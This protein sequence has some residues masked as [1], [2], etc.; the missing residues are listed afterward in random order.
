MLIIVRCS[1][2][3]FVLLL[4]CQLANVSAHQPGVGHHG[5]RGMSGR[6]CHGS[7]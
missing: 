2:F 7:S 3:N 4:H 1:S 6:R 5:G